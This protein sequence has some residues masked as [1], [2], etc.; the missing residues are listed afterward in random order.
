M[1]NIEK[2]RIYQLEQDKGTIVGEENLEVYITEY[3]KKIFGAP[4]KNNFTMQEDVIA[5]IP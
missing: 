2:K 1:K 3:Y 4:A 5:D